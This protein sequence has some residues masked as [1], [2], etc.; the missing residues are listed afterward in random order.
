VKVAASDMFVA[1]SVI[2]TIAAVTFGVTIGS[3]DIAMG[4]LIIVSML[5]TVMLGISVL[6]EKVDKLMKR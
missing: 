2:V 5:V 3:K 4:T 6:L 1:W